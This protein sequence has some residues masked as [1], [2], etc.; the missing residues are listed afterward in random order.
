MIDLNAILFYP[1][2]EEAELCE[3]VLKHKS[4]AAI[5]TEGK[6]TADTMRKRVAKLRQNAGV[7]TNIQLLYVYCMYKN[8]MA[9]IS[10]VAK[11]PHSLL[12]S[13]EMQHC[14]GCPKGQP[15]KQLKKF[16]E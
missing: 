7:A 10:P 15:V 6:I 9:A 16:V 1:T 5:P 13:A 11:L 14:L 3:L 2:K 12:R 8:R 4:I